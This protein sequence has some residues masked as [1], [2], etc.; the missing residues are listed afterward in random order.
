MSL[1][2]VRLN[3]KCPPFRGLKDKI[4]NTYAL[5]YFLY[6][7]RIEPSFLL[8]HLTR[9]TLPTNISYQ[10]RFN[11]DIPMLSYI[12]S[13]IIR[14][15]VEELIKKKYIRESILRRNKKF[16]DYLKDLISRIKK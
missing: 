9:G 16:F 4:L 5:A 6:R 10:L 11:F 14:Y 15:G 3:E 8:F 7:N 13:D 2:D 12:Y 1:C